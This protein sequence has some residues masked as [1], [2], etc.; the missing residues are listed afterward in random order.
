[1]VVAELFSSDGYYV[2]GL[3]K[4]DKN[5]TFLAEFLQVD[6]RN[7]P[8]CLKVI[9]F[10]KEKYKKISCIVHC[11]GVMHSMPAS[12]VDSKLLSES[13]AVN[14]QFP[15]LL[16]SLLTK[17]LSRGKASVIF[18]GSV[19]SDICINGELVY[20]STKSTLKKVTKNFAIELGRLGIR[21]FLI[22]PS[23]CVSPMTSKLPQ[24]DFDYMVSRSV[25]RKALS[26]E[27]VASQI[28]QICKYDTL[29]NGTVFE[30]GGSI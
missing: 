17:N 24:D 5:I 20:S 12:R 18:I 4:S 10:I 8:E 26:C 3:S 30:C 13:F 27:E 21:F 7:E 19:A 9:N 2:I 29:L 11:A 15:I 14:V 16:T 6:F 28:F 25:A 22:K 1:M 23:I